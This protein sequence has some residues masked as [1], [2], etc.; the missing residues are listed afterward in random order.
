VDWKERKGIVGLLVTVVIIIIVFLLPLKIP[1]S[2]HVE[3]KILP[4]R[5]WILQKQLDGSILI[6][7]NDHRKNIVNKVSAYQ[8]DRGDF[9]EFSLNPKI[10]EK[11]VIS[12]NDTIGLISSNETAR[13]L[14]ELKGRLSSAQASLDVSLAGEKETIV[15]IA[16]E[17]LN[18]AKERLANQRKILERKN[19]L[20][21]NKLISEEEYEIV[22]TTAN[23]LELE[24]VAAQANLE[25]LKSG[26]KPEQIDFLRIEIQSIEEEINMLQ[27]RLKK[28]TLK[29]PMDG[30][31]LTL[32]SS[33]TLLI[34]GDT[35]SAVIMPVNMKYHSSI[36]KAQEFTVDLRLANSTEK[37]QGQIK[38]ISNVIRYIN[39]QEVLFVTGITNSPLESLPINM[40]V[41]CSIEGDGLTLRQHIFRY[42]NLFF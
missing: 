38:K 20:Y 21:E 11:N 39:N 36:Q 22:K 40:V 2:I 41:P 33:D 8:V 14:A 23:I 12:K 5:E 30:R 24:L 10:Y 18:Q 17:Q 13:Q 6:T 3:G 4:A 35:I 42:L 1:Y 16:E 31:L 37:V 7:E 28:F 32:F 9:V 15:R 19:D 25:N 29:S 34:V 27:D 26:A